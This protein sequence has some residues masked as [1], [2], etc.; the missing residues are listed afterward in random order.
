MMTGWSS[1]GWRR[2]P[3]RGNQRRMAVGRGSIKWVGLLRNLEWGRG[4][5]SNEPQVKMWER[6]G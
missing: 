2:F 3:V 5:K 4:K 1:A 6:T